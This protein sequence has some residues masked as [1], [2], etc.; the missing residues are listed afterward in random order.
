MIVNNSILAYRIE[1]DYVREW[2][3]AWCLCIIKVMLFTLPVVMD[4][5]SLCLTY[6]IENDF[7]REWFKIWWIIDV[8]FSKIR[9]MISN[10]FLYV[11]FNDPCLV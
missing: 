5:F 1:N 8:M 7:I 10:V 9:V 2:F 6:R 11:Y 4:D 3:K